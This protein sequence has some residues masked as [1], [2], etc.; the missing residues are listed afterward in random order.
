MQAPGWP[1]AGAQRAHGPV[2][3]T[4]LLPR[5]AKFLL[6]LL[7][8]GRPASPVGV[9]V[10]L[11]VPSPVCPPPTLGDKLAKAVLFYCDSLVTQHQ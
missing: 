7:P 10:R 6:P 5:H 4:R 9:A 1:R 8:P 2:T 11:A 3:H